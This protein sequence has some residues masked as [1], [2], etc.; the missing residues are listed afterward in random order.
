[1]YVEASQPFEATFGAGVS[2]LVGTVEVAVED[3]DGNVV[4]GPTAANISEINISGV[5]TGVYAWNAPAAPG[6]LGQYTIIWSPD[7]TWDPDTASVPEDLVIVDQSAGPLPPIPPPSEGG[8]TVGPCTAWVTG[9][10][11]AACCS[12]ESSSGALFDEVADQASQL[13]YA[14]SGRQFSGL[15]ERTV[16]PP[17]DS[18]YCGYQV[19]SRGY[20]IGPWDWGYPLWSLCDSCLIACAPSRIKLA[21]YPVREITQVKINGD[22]LASSEY[23]LFN[24]RYL[25]RLND[26][27]W[28]VRQ[29]LTLPDSEDNTFSVSYT[30]GASPPMMGVAAAAQLGC[31]LYRACGGEQCALPQGTTR[32]IQQGIVIEK[33]A[34]TSWAFRDGTWRTGMPLVDAFLQSVN[35]RG[36]QQRSTFWAPGKRQYAQMFG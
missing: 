16:R 18:C 28:P 3:N 22:V 1:M 10:D 20:V 30:Y 7:G 23:T 12:V 34:F 13:L 4:I 21:G 36:L 14:L 5:D 31:E 17:C 35:P 19:L 32:V 25:T 6:T 24:Y 15:C 11:V 2:G 26:E 27:R 8:I 9:D 33:L 29:D